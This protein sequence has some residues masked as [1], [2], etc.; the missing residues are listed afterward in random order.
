MQTERE[1]LFLQPHLKDV[2]WGGSKLRD[3][4]NYEGAGDSTGECWGICAHPNGDAVVSIG[5]YKGMTLSKLYKDHR[6]LFGNL[7][8]MEFPLLVKIIDTRE[9]LSIQVHPH[10]AYVKTH[11]NCQN[12]KSECWYIMDCP[13]N[14]FLIIG[15]HAKS[16][17]QLA[18]LIHQGRYEEL[19]R[20]I[21]VKKGDFIQ[22][23]PG[24]VHAIEG[25]FTILE[26]QQ[27]SD[28]TYRVYD[29]GRLV[30][31]KPRPLHVEQSVDVIN[32]PDM[33]SAEAVVQTDWLPI[34]QLNQLIVCDF[35]KVF[36]LVVKG[37]TTV[38]QKYPFLAV[39][40]LDGKGSIGGTIVKKGDHLILPAGFGEAVF[41]GNMELILSTV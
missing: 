32:V 33:T 34:N 25:G 9:S 18:D 41:S 20:R 40:V 23:A 31:G 27:S 37:S 7:K 38:N 2:V 11:E 36:K 16:R 28:I 30:N 26:T 15:H 1:I 3:E 19:I 10:D 21:P 35:Y 13:T 24:T 5:N 12:G 4:F 14:A 22:I 8:A 17:K 39:S 29:Y 6:E